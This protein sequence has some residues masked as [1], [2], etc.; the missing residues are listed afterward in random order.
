LITEFGATA[1]KASYVCR[2]CGE[3]FEAFKAI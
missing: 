1:C 2:D 3:P